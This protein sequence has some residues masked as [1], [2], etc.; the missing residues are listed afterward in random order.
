MTCDWRV[1]FDSL[2]QV[3]RWVHRVW[4]EGGGPGFATGFPGMGFG[5]GLGF[6]GRVICITLGISTFRCPAIVDGGTV[7]YRTV[8]RSSLGGFLQRRVLIYL[9]KTLKRTLHGVQMY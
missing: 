5:L 4:G 3:W 8:R 6:G 1:V 7:C 9:W 2:G